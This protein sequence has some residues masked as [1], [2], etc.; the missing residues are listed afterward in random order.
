MVVHLNVVL[1]AEALLGL[2]QGIVVAAT[3]RCFGVALVLVLHVAGPTLC[4]MS[5]YL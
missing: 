2:I 5:P 3:C 4:E 1:L